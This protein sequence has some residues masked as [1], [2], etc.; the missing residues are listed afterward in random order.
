MQES[1]I[2]A[3]VPLKEE[4]DKRKYRQQSNRIFF[5]VTPHVYICHVVVNKMES[6]KS[7]KSFE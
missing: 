6:D 4:V 3:H 2:S 5:F 7:T 1:I